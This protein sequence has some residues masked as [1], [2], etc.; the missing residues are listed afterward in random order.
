MVE[1]KW[2]ILSDIDSQEVW[3]DVYK[4]FNFQP[5]FETNKE[6]YSINQT[7][8]LYDCSEAIHSADTDINWTITIQ[9][10]TNITSK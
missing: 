3:N 8:D 9:N 10:I 7:Y 5:D 4:K 2:K 6:V 1:E